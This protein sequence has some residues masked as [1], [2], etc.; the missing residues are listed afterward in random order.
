MFPIY[1]IVTGQNCVLGG[2]VRCGGIFEYLMGVAVTYH[3]KG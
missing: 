1:P 3:Y 2:W